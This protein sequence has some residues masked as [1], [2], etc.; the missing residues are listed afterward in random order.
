MTYPDGH[1]VMWILKM[2]KVC[3]LWKSCRF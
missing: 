2:S 3:L 1:Y